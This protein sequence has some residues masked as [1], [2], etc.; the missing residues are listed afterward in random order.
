MLDA[1]AFL[2]ACWT[3]GTLVRS[4]CA[5]VLIPTAA[6]LAIRLFSKIIVRSAHDPGWQAPLAAAAASI[7]GLLLVVLA[8][9]ALIAGADASCRATWSGQVLFALIVSVIA[10]A[11]IRATILALKRMSEARAL[12][13]AS[14]PAVGRLAQIAGQT[15]IAARLMQDTSLVCV[16]AGTWRPLVV[17]SSGALDCLSDAELSAAL[18]HERGHA[19][20]GDQ[21]I[22]FLLTFLV[23][24]LPLPAADL[25]R[26]YRRARELAADRHA[27]QSVDA[28]DLAS[29]LLRFAKPTR[30]VAATAAFD[31]EA[32]VVA[33][34]DVLLRDETPKPV[35][36]LQRGALALS[37]VAILLLGVAPAAATL[38][39]PLPCTMDSGS[40]K[41]V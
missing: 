30:F 6:W 21:L 27:L 15:Q 24:L 4:V 31:G 8:A 25:V 23:D 39:Y 10:L 14:L 28:H 38:V 13:Q 2:V 18:H 26:T 33:R 36:V 29:A 41:M 37:L 5:V 7:P 35:S 11:F 12:I 1:W 19:R 32:T 20:R 22:A 40:M 3:S 16:L 34:L 9:A 17:V